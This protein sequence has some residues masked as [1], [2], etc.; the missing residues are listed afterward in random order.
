[1]ANEFELTLTSVRTKCLPPEPGEVNGNGKPVTQKIYWDAKLPGFGLLVGRKKKTFIVQRAVFGKTIRQTIDSYPT[2][3]VQQA[4][5]A[6]HEML[7]KLR[8]G[9]DP[10][11][12]A[13]AQAESNR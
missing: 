8:K 7:V 11:A 5:D 3:T 6:A 1:M 12:E 10:K 4:R 9:E 13:K 2:I